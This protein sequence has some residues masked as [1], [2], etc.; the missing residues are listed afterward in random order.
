[1]SLWL[2]LLSLV[3]AAAGLQFVTRLIVVGITTFFP[4]LSWVYQLLSEGGGS[5][6]TPLY[7]INT[8]ILAPLVE[9]TAFRGI[10]L[11]YARK[12]MPFWVANLWQALLFGVC[13]TSFVT[14]AYAFVMGAVMG[15]FFRKGRS[16][17][18][19]ILIHMLVNLIA[20]FASDAIVTCYDRYFVLSA[21]FGIALTM[22]AMWL[23]S[24]EI[25]KK[26]ESEKP[27]ENL[28]ENEK[29]ES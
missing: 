13:H 6:L 15:Y 21:V 27:S 8:V 1:M 16:M 5:N 9:E 24:K 17:G 3:L 20:T 18:Y 10:T 25:Q 2:V 29:Q 28:S 26:A 22:F 23:F 4:D 12:I 19:T 7:V 14:G 11:N